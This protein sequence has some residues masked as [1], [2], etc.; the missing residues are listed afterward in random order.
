VARALALPPGSPLVLFAAGRMV[1]WC[2]H[3]LEQRLDPGLL[4]PRARPTLSRRDR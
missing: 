4:R 1:G 2:A 3:V